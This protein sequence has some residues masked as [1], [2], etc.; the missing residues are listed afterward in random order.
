[1]CDEL[2]ENKKLVVELFEQAL[3]RYEAEYDELFEQWRGLESKAQVA[4]AT[5]GIFISASGLLVK[6]V[7]STFPAG[8]NLTLVIAIVALIVSVVFS[9]RVLAVRQLKSSPTGEGY[10]VLALRALEEMEHQD[11]RTANLKVD[12]IQDKARLWEDGIVSLKEGNKLKA[13]RLTVAQ[14]PLLLGL[15]LVAIATVSAILWK[16]SKGAIG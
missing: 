3:E 7:S 5:S 11:G 6:E 1:M 16:Q 14:H 8:I 2:S 15:T 9:V 10:M 13:N 4:L 12:D